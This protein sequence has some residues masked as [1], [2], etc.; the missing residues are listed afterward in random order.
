MTDLNSLLPANSGWQLEAAQAINDSG[1]IAGY[2]LINGETHA[3]LMNT[4]AVAPE[5]GSVALVGVAG[6]FLGLARKR[7]RRARK[8]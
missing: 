1:Q 8:V 4:E 6:A 7:L 3:F 5:P 2:G